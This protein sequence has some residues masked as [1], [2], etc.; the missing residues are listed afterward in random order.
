[1][2]AEKRVLQLDPRGKIFLLVLVNVIAFTYEEPWIE[3]LTILSLAFL[4]ILCGCSKTAVKWL[5]LFG[6]LVMVQYFLLPVMP[7]FLAVIMT[8]FTVFLRKIFPCFMMGALII[9]TSPVGH[10]IAALRTWK[11]PQNVIIPLAVTLRYFPAIGEEHK[12]IRDAMKLKE[13]HGLG[14]RIECSMIPLLVSAIQ[15]SDELSAAAITRGID[16]P[17]EKTSIIELKLH[18]QDYLCL[19]F[20]AVVAVYSVVCG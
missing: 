13:V 11:V 7:K 8:I 1:M 18:V 6:V 14:K 16:N 4:Q 20:A 19:L 3:L 9:K 5:I 17:C 10:F 12:H 15:T 2:N